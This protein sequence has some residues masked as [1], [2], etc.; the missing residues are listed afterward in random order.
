M[1]DDTPGTHLLSKQTVR[2]V[3][4]IAWRR[5]LQ[6]PIDPLPTLRKK[7]FSGG[8]VICK[9]EGWSFW[10]SS[11]ASARIDGFHYEEN[12]RELTLGGEGEVIVPPYLTWDDDL[13]TPIDDATAKRILFRMTAAMQWSGSSV[14]FAFREE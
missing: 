1:G 9:D 5:E 4:M 8:R 12:G 2:V 13:S 11:S 7:W 3:R 10:V 6:Q 14:W